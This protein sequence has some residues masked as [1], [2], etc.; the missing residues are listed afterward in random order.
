MLIFLFFRRRNRLSKT[1]CFLQAVKVMKQLSLLQQIKWKVTFV[2]TLLFLFF[3]EKWALSWWTSRNRWFYNR[4]FLF[5]K[6]S[7]SAPSKKRKVF[8]FEKNAC[9]QKKK[10]KVVSVPSSVLKTTITYRFQIFVFSS[11]FFFSCSL[12]SHS[13]F[14]RST[15][16]NYLLRKLIWRSP[17]PPPSPDHTHT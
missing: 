14:F 7:W 10:K 5:W 16:V 3:F 12:G 11:S 9:N 4:I 1:C 17:V 2:F 8:F 13:Q 15:E 6:T